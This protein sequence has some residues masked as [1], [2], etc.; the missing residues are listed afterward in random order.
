MTKVMNK[1]AR[2]A[3]VTGAA[4]GIGQAT[5]IEFARKG[6]DLVIADIQPDK[7][8]QVAEKIRQLGRDV[9][10]VECDVSDVEAIRALHDKIDQTFGRLDAACNNAGIEGE[11]TSTLDCS[12]DNWER[13]MAVNV[14]S[15]FVCMQEQIRRMQGHGGAIV[16]VSS[17]AGLVG[18]AE[19]PAYCASKGAV[20]QLTRAAAIEYAEQ[21]IRVNAICPG[22]I[23]TDMVDRVTGEDPD[24]EAQYAAF[25]PMNRMGTADEVAATIVFFCEPGAGFITGQAL[26]VDGG[27][28]AR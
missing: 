21:G 1:A 6:Y 19:R 5:A 26:A 18:F 9:L 22:V 28:V 25:H 27:M 7:L 20:I 15:V 13:V 11:A 12:V 16:N 10:A 3:L 4:A 17:V 14:R 23:K 2:V 24:V 8:E